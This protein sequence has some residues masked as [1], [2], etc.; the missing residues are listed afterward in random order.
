MDN[1]PTPLEN[2]PVELLRASDWQ[3][4]FGERAAIEGI[5]SQLKPHLAVEVGSAAGG[6]LRRIAHHSERVHTFDL[7]RPAPSVAHRPN[8]RLHTGDSRF[9]LPEWL[10]ELRRP[11]DFALIDGDHSTEGVRADLTALLSSRWCRRTVFLLHDSA[12]AETR[13]G[14][15]MA[16]QGV[17]GVVY[18]DMDFLPGYVFARG[19][20]AGERW[21]GFALIVTG[22]ASVALAQDL[23]RST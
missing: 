19:G 4:S 14:I 9:L 13:A 22:D 7:A 23:Y 12:H 3:M 6:S 15:E 1:V 10:E 17:S 5:L 18:Q 11:I 21:G 2:V 8:V 20:F 16:L